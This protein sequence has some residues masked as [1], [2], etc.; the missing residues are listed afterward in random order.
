MWIQS[1][2]C[3]TLQKNYHFLHCDAVLQDWWRGSFRFLTF[4][5]ITVWAPRT[6]ISWVWVTREMTVRFTTNP[7]ACLSG[8]P[9]TSSVGTRHFSWKRPV[10]ATYSNT[11]PKKGNF[12]VRQCLIN[13]K[14]KHDRNTRG[15]YVCWMYSI[16]WR[17]RKNFISTFSLNHYFKNIFKWDTDTQSALS[18]KCCQKTATV[19][20]SNLA[21]NWAKET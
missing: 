11:L 3:R 17:M 14:M 10:G 21:T 5:C 2:G 1:H 9:N 8:L 7:P 16:K 18:G 4:L 13:N 20:C 12:R 19:S 6:E 15:M